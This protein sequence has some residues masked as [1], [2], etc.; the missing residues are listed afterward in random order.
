VVVEVEVGLRVCDLA[1]LGLGVAVFQRCEVGIHGGVE[2][3]VEVRAALLA[4]AL[5]GPVE[6]DR[7]VDV[8]QLVVCVVAEDRRGQGLLRGPVADV[9]TDLHRLLVRLRDP[10]ILGR[11]A[12]IGPFCGRLADGNPH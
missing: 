7:G 5:V 10:S 12:A 1:G 6:E 8:D 4:A 2:E 11:G 9:L 3:V